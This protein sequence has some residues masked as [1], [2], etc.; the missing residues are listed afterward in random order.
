LPRSIVQHY[1]QIGNVERREQSGEERGEDSRASEWLGTGASHILCGEEHSSQTDIEACVERSE[2]HSTCTLTRAVVWTGTGIGIWRVSRAAQRKTRRCCTR[3]E[4]E[5]GKQADR[6]A[7]WSAASRHLS[8]WT[9]RRKEMEERA[10][11]AEAERWKLDICH[12]DTNINILDWQMRA[13]ARLSRELRWRALVALSRYEV[14]YTVCWIGARGRCCCINC[15]PV[16]DETCDG[17]GENRE[18]RE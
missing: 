9:S 10:T 5:R 2:A 17:R 4:R 6:E 7:R 12:E 15:G 13:R 16:R 1:E 18:H 8:R 14:R 3:R 11:L